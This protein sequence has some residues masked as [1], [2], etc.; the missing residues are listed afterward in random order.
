MKKL[1][2]IVIAGLITC[3]VFA[4]SDDPAP[5]KHDVTWHRLVV[6]DF[7]PGKAGEAKKIIENFLEK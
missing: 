3:G 6:V 2:L 1:A 4:Q 7:K 5:S